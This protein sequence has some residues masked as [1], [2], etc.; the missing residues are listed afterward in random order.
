MHPERQSIDNVGIQTDRPI[1]ATVVLSG[2]NLILYSIAFTISLLNLVNNSW[3]YQFG[4]VTIPLLF[5]SKVITVVFYGM[6]VIFHSVIF[7]KYLRKLLKFMSN[8]R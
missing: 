6:V 7:I 1:V 5:N 8:K 4:R 2:I 3:N